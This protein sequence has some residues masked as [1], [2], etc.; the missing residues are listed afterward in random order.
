MG[1]GLNDYTVNIALGSFGVCK[2]TKNRKLPF[3]MERWRRVQGIFQL[4]LLPRSAHR[5]ILHSDSRVAL[6]V[7]IYPQKSQF[8]LQGT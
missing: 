8:F 7:G 3:T 4:E 5:E 2:D 1:L 6:L